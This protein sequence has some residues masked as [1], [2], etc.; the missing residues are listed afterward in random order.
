MNDYL[1]I[2]GR[3]LLLYVIVIFVFRVMGK[4]EVGELSLVDFAIYVLI[5]EVGSLALEDLEQPLMLA[6]VPIFILLVI[7]Y[8]NSLLILKNKKMRDIIDGDPAIIIRDGLIVEAEMRKHRY[9]LDDLFQQLREQGITSVQSI[10]YAFLEQSGKLS[11]FEKENSPFILPLI[12]DGHVDEK[13]LVLIG[14]D[15]KWVDDELRKQGIYSAQD[16]FYACCV[17]NKLQ[18]Q[19]KAR[20]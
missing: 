18:V 6:I 17:D 8:V 20:E 14:K 4:R 19:L 2:S 10:S 5:A 9:N 3:T 12:I 16:V 15:Q 11:V 1:L 7:Q 13:H